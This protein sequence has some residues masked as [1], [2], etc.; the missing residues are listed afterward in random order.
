[1]RHLHPSAMRSFRTGPVVQV[2]TV[3]GEPD[4]LAFHDPG[5]PDSYLSMD[6]PINLRE[7]R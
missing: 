4:K 3:A 6:D 2:V 1:M 5:T 7:Y